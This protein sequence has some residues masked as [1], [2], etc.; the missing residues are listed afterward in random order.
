MSINLS[1]KKVMI[2]GKSLLVLGLLGNP[3]GAAQASDLD[4][5]AGKW[6]VGQVTTLHCT[7]SS[8]LVGFEAQSLAGVRY[9]SLPIQYDFC[10]RLQADQVEARNLRADDLLTT[11][12]YLDEGRDGLVGFKSFVPPYHRAIVD[13]RLES[14]KRIEILKKLK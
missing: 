14:N 10:E 9:F 8:S 3:Q 12:L 2:F 7:E 5:I 6:S 11:S 13:T 1:A 4:L